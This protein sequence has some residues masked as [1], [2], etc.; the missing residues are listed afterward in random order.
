VDAQAVAARTYAA[1]VM[2]SSVAGDEYDI[3]DSDQCQVY[4]GRAHF[5][6]DGS[7][8][9]TQFTPAVSDTSYLVLQYKGGPAFAQF[10]ASNG[11][12]TVAG[13]QPYLPA[14]SDPYDTAQRSFDPYIGVTK[15]VSVAMIARYFGLKTVSTLSITGR[16]GHGTW[17]GR[18]LTGSV[19]GKDSKGV[20]RVKPATGYDLAGAFGLG[21]TW[22]KAVGVS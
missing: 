18:V 13:G 10:S 8:A 7:T 3:C 22:L 16:D 2:A 11:G 12:W 5:R 19:T 20:T 1:N 6:A 17:G 9:W 21:T 4:G 15:K 14:K